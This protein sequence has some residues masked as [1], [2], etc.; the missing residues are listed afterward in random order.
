FKSSKLGIKCYLSFFF[1]NSPMSNANFFSVSSSNFPVLLI[2]STI[3]GFE[4]LIEY[5]DLIADARYLGLFQLTVRD[6]AALV[7]VDMWFLGEISVEIPEADSY[8]PGDPK[9]RQALSKH[10]IDFEQRLTAAINEGSLKTTK[11]LRNL[12]EELD[13]DKTLIDQDDLVSWLVS[14]GHEPGDAFEDYLHEEIRILEKVLS[15]IYTLRIMRKNVELS[16]RNLS[17]AKRNPEKAGINELRLA[18]KELM[19]ENTELFTSKMQL[20]NKLQ[21]APKYYPEKAEQKLST[22]SR[23][24]LLTIIG[25]LCNK[26]GIEYQQR[27]AAKRIS[28]FTEE[29]G[30]A[31]TDDTIRKIINEI[32]DAI[33]SRLK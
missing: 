27:G 5:E 8:D 23:R 18:V 32:D 28:E 26:S 17:E 21:E 20:K 11:I 29:I 10:C 30:A 4:D 13:L 19:I 9:L 12:S 22:R 24:T 1:L 6:A 3:S 33:E 16:S 14:C 25:A 7:A 31:V 2:F 15:E